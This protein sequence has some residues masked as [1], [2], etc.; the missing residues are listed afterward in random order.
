MP[1]ISTRVGTTALGLLLVAQLGLALM[2]SAGEEALQDQR[3]E[4]PLVGGS[5]EGV[6]RIAI[7]GP[8]GGQV[9]LIKEDGAWRLPDYFDAPAADAEVARLLQRLSGVQRGLPIATT[10]GAAQRFKVDDQG[11][12]RRI[13][14]YA[15]EEVRTTL[16]L[17]ESP[18]RRQTYARPAHDAA[19]Y[20][21][22]LAAYEVPA[23]PE[24]W[25]DAELMAVDA[26]A[27]REIELPDGARLRRSEPG[28]QAE[29]LGTGAGGERFDPA[30]AQALAMRL[31]GIRVERLIGTEP[32]A[33][34]PALTIDAGTAE[35]RFRWRLWRSDDAEGEDG[36][37]YR[38]QRSDRPWV[39]E[40]PAWSAE[41]LIEA[42]RPSALRRGKADE[43]RAAGS[44]PDS[45]AEPL[46]GVR[47]PE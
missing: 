1:R 34:P 40:L 27:I 7:D 18:G 42:A 8:E 22:E 38:L 45:G 46:S 43:E 30:A 9:T 15:G 32:P 12:E 31:G 21:V 4:T 37:R 44:S 13:R 26:R 24:S 11:F 41:P 29:G 10:P 47:A 36:E 14:L 3:P 28:W 6:D 20:A 39:A 5:L 17:G 2:L 16:Y 25:L 19:V 35:D 23:K 33:E